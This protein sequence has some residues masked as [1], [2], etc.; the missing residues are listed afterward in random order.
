MDSIFNQ[1]APHPPANTGKKRDRFDSVRFLP[2]DAR[3]VNCLDPMRYF[4][5]LIQMMLLLAG[6]TGTSHAQQLQWESE[7]LAFKPSP[8][9][10][11]IV[12]H[13]KFKNT[14]DTEAN[15]ASV[16]SSCSCTTPKLEKK[17]FAPGESDEVTVT[18]MIGARTGLQE[19]VIVVEGNDPKRPI[20]MLRMKVAIP[21]A[22]QLHPTSLYWPPSEPLSSK[23]ISLELTKGFPVKTVTVES[24]N[25]KISAH[26]EAVKPGETYRIIVTPQETDQPVTAILS[27]KTDYPPENPKTFYINVQAQPKK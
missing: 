2:K 18:F 23:E 15:I 7:E 19:K 1:I 5:V 8:T 26:A 10:K 22:A 6:L 17:N 27:I 16:K 24:S 11:A 20:T 9:D 12:A 13:F 4:L 25:P 14:G 21:E 3:A